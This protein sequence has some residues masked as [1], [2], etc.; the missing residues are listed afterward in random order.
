MSARNIA[1][2]SRNRDPTH[3]RNRLQSLFLTLLVTAAFVTIAAPAASSEPLALFSDLAELTPANVQSL[4]PLVPREVAAKFDNR[5]LLRQQHSPAHALHADSSADADPQLQRF[6]DQRLSLQLAS[7]EPARLPPSGT[8]RCEISYV[9]G[10]PGAAAEPAPG[11]PGERELRAWDPIE[12]RVVWSVTEALPTSARP[13]VTAGGLVF[14]GTTD[15]WL[16]A[17]DAR[18]GRTLWKHRTE[19]REL[20]QPFSYLGTDGHQYIGV[21]SLPHA[22][23]GGREALLIFALAH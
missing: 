7:E 15:G 22:P 16:K 19:H 20:D 12:R 5:P 14:Y 9:I 11:P 4:L 1:L 2:A 21:H 18:T 10:T 8:P 23:G 13:L 3:G 6:I 17:L